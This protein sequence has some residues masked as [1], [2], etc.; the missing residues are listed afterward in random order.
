MF[1]TGDV[2]ARRW[3]VFH[4]LLVTSTPL[5]SVL[6]LSLRGRLAGVGGMDLYCADPTGAT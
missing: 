6:A 3:P 4:D 5:H 2:L 1:A